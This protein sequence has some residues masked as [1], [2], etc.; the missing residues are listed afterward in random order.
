MQFLCAIRNVTTEKMCMKKNEIVTKWRILCVRERWH[1]GFCN[2]TLPPFSWCTTPHTHKHS[3]IKWGTATETYFIS[4]AMQSAYFLWFDFYSSF[5]R[6]IILHSS[7]RFSFGDDMHFFSNSHIRFAFI[8]HA[9]WYVTD[10]NWS[11]ILSVVIYKC[12]KKWSTPF[13]PH[14]MSQF[15]LPYNW[16]FDL[17]IFCYLL[18]FC[19]CIIVINVVLLAQNVWIACLWYCLANCVPCARVFSHKFSSIS[20]MEFQCL[21]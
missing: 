13:R 9:K 5:R 11:R 15:S 6:W 19:M 4:R 12:A 1:I 10:M 8:L 14:G 21:M 2:R 18:E 17:E 20:T 7:T 16:K 3:R